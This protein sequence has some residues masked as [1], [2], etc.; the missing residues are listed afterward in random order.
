MQRSIQF[1]FPDVL[2]GSSWGPKEVFPMT[3]RSVLSHPAAHALSPSRPMSWRDLAGTLHRMWRAAV[4][5]RQLARLDDRALQDIG[6]SR[7]E[8]LAEAG[9]APWDLGPRR[10]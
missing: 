8:A 1:V 2:A 5:R 9:R 7:A 10:R 3:I 4:T 6:I